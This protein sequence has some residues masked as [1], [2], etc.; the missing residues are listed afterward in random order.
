MADH[1]AAH[2]AIV[3]LVTDAPAAAGVL[4]DLGDKDLLVLILIRLPVYELSARR[5]HVLQA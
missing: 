2:A 1:A 5:L 3:V 4:E